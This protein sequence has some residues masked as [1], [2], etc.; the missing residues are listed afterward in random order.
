M[1]PEVQVYL[2]ILMIVGVIM[3]TPLIFKLFVLLG[4]VL[5][6]TFWPVSTVSLEV[7]EED[8]SVIIKKIKLSNT[9]DLIKNLLK[10]KQK[11]KA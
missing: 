1:Q 6:M 3:S 2:H 8:G 11:G 9:D 4:K 5:V 7:V 10:A